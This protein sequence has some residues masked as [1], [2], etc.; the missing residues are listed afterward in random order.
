MRGCVC[1]F[2]CSRVCVCLGACVG[3]CVG[4][5]ARVRVWCMSVYVSVC[6]RTGVR[7]LVPV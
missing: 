1:V 4:A 3:A 5:C 6:W 7:V 2:F